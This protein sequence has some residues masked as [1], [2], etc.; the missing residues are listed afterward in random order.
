V[1][2]A[3]GGGK[4][5]MIILRRFPTRVYQ[6]RKKDKHKIRKATMRPLT[7]QNLAPIWLPHCPAWMCTISLMV[8]LDSLSLLLPA[9]GYNNKYDSSVVRCGDRSIPWRSHTNST[10]INTDSLGRSIDR[11]IQRI[12]GSEA[13]A[14]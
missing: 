11:L 9:L 14:N 7:S 1:T 12:V 2:A 4:M 10:T 13:G 8:A 6:H 3:L 5:P